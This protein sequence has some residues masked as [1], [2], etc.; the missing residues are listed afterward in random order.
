[1]DEREKPSRLMRFV[2]MGVVALLLLVLI[3]LF[4][5]I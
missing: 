3:W 5:K 2:A 4:I 1:M